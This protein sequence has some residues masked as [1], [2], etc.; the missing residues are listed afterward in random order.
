MAG[1]TAEPSKGHVAFSPPWRFDGGS[2]SAPRSP[3]NANFQPWEIRNFSASWQTQYRTLVAAIFD[4]IGSNEPWDSI[5]SVRT[6]HPRVVAKQ[7]DVA[8]GIKEAVWV[9]PL[10]RATRKVKDTRIC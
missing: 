2:D 4:D 7:G 3:Q 10:I 8:T 5:L 9:Y 6:M 1:V